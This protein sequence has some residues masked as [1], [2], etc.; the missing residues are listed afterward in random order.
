MSEEIKQV[1]EKQT[2]DNKSSVDNFVVSNVEEYKEV[3]EVKA[4]VWMLKT[5][6]GAFLTFALLMVLGIGFYMVKNPTDSTIGGSTL[7]QIFSVIKVIIDGAF[8]VQ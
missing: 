1:P 7:E 6:L 2:T 4:K 8:N 3:E 5:G